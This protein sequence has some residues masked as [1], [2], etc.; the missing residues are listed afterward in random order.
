MDVQVRRAGELARAFVAVIEIDRPVF[1]RHTHALPSHPLKSLLSY[2]IFK[3][4]ARDMTQKEEKS[5]QKLRIQ[6]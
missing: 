2:H 6:P 1:V 5:R 4:N 3:T